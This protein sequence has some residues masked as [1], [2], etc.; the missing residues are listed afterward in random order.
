M[1]LFLIWISLADVIY[2][3]KLNDKRY[4]YPFF[5]IRM[6]DLSGTILAYVFYGS[7]LCE[8]LKIAKCTL[9]F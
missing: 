3:C 1:L 2:K 5:I 9:K 4:N 7:V 6:S 8:F